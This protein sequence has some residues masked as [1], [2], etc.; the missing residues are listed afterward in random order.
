M[1]D[2]YQ[3]LPKDDKWGCLVAALIG[4]PV[5][6]F[7]TMLDALGDCAPDPDCKKGFFSMVL[8]PSLIVTAL[9][10]GGVKAIVRLLQSRDS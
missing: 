10:F 2:G 4:F 9:V 8:V 6:V 1:S 3:G 5:F 7:L